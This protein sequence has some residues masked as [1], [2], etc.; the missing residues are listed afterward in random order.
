MKKL[1]TLLKSQGGFFVL[2]RGFDSSLA[3]LQ[4]AP[5]KDE[6]VVRFFCILWHSDIFSGAVGFSC[7]ICFLTCLQ[8]L[9]F[10]ASQL[11]VRNQNYSKIIQTYIQNHYYSIIIPFFSAESYVI[12]K[13]K[14]SE[15]VD[16]SIPVL[17]YWP[18]FVFALF[19]KWKNW[20]KWK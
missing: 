13:N 14:S 8:Q 17:K 16:G 1:L 2:L 18:F 6:L 11:L 19:L 20:G 9:E 5:R 3:S 15:K 12:S 4:P 10:V 7:W